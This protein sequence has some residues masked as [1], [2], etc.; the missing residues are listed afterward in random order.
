MLNLSLSGNFLSS[1][2]HC[3]SFDLISL[4]INKKLKNGVSLPTPVDLLGGATKCKLIDKLSGSYVLLLFQA[5]PFFV[6]SNNL[7]SWTL[8]GVFQHSLLPR[9]YLCDNSSLRW[10]RTTKS[11]WV[12]FPE[13]CTLSDYLTLLYTWLFSLMFDLWLVE[14]PRYILKIHFGEFS[15]VINIL[16]KL[17]ALMI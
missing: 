4:A 12:W 16:R 15:F 17:F 7:K 8:W 13:K 2:Y 3:M 5:K 14:T 9:F 10:A 6:D 1:R 11:A